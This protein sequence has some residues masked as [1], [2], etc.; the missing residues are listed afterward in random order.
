MYFQ[1]RLDD[2]IKSRGQ[3]VSPKE[4]ENVIYELTGVTG[5]VVIGIEDP[6]LGSAIK[7]FLTV[8]PALAITESEVLRHCAQRLEDFM[9]PKA[10]EIV[11]T[12]PT[13]DSG[14]IRRRS[15]V[16][17]DDRADLSLPV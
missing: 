11:S 1:G 2:I 6:V 9:V 5:A 13:T 7:A 16:S 8:D 14:K 12:L 4:V 3:R 15:L 17:P 10:V